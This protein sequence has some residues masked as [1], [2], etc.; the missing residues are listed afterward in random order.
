MRRG[1]IGQLRGAA[2]AQRDQVLSGD[3]MGFAADERPAAEAAPQRWVCEDLRD[4]L[5]AVP[6]VGGVVAPGLSGRPLRLI[7]RLAAVAD[8]L[9][10]LAA[11]SAGLR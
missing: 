2:M 1:E 11:P 4:N 6:V 9:A 10:G 8:R 3:L 5:T 7:Q